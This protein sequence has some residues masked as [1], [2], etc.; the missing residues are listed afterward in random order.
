VTL[1]AGAGSP[2]M[3]TAGTSKQPDARPAAGARCSASSLA[4]YAAV[5]FTRVLRMAEPLGSPVFSVLAA[6]LITAFTAGAPIVTAHRWSRGNALGDEL[7]EHGAI[8]AYSRDIAQHLLELTEAAIVTAEHFTELAHDQLER[9]S[10]RIDHGY[11]VVV[12]GLQ[13][14]AR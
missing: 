11:R 12:V 7:R 4:V 8:T 14:A 2:A 1:T 10:Q 9:A 6:A 13:K 5:M 3:S